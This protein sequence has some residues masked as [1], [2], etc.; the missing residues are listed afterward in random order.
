MPPTEWPRWETYASSLDPTRFSHGHDA[1]HGSGILRAMR[2]SERPDQVGERDQEMPVVL[3]AEDEETI[4]ESL[5]MIVEEAGYRAIV[6]L[7]G[8]Q[9]LMLARQR[10][11]ELILTDL[12]MPFLS[13]AD[14][15]A[16]IRR[17]AAA[18]GEEAPPIALITAASRARAEE[19]GADVVVSKPFDVVKIEELLH[20]FLDDHPGPTPPRTSGG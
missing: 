1:E 7:D 14:L 17:D 15:I 4:A 11:P 2:A 18:S 20:Q 9:A 6:A 13:G 5:A 16:S 19:A 12:M 10:R 3:I 8:R